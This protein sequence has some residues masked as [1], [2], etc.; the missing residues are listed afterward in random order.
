MRLRFEHKNDHNLVFLL[1]SMPPPR[2]P[3]WI[4]PLR[5]PVFGM[6]WYTTNTGEHIV[7]YSGGG[8]S[9][10]TGVHNHVVVQTKTNECSIS[11]GEKVGIAVRLYGNQEYLYLLVSVGDEIQRYALDEETARLAGSIHLPQYDQGGASLDDMCNA[12]AVNRTKDRL[13][14][15]CE[16]GLVRLYGINDDDTN[17][18]AAFISI[19]QGHIKAVCAVQFSQTNDDTFVSSAKDGTARVWNI[20]KNHLVR[21]TA[22]LTCDCTDPTAKKPM[23]PGTQI[24]VRGCA[25]AGTNMIVTVASPRRGAAFLTGW[26]RDA[27]GFGVGVRTLV[28][29]VPVSAM[30]SSG[31]YVAMGTVDGSII[32][33]NLETWKI[34]RKFDQVHELPVTCLSIRP[35]FDSTDLDITVHVRSASADSKLACLSLQRKVPKANKPERLGSSNTGLLTFIHRIIVGL[36]LLWV[37][38]PM[39]QDASDACGQYWYQSDGSF[40]QRV[41]DVAHCVFEDVLWAPGHRP[42]VATPPY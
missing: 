27:T 11:T 15:G 38:S 26:R 39:I 40:L 30:D 7:A 12:M 20:D 4:D 37:I 25:F 6:A 2:P 3:S 33:W 19:C 16:S 22:T 34:I 24:L 21:S 35:Q 1:T 31:P 42:G 14:L 10:K 36:F 29:P 5:V 41:E 32:L 13:I 17:N 23:K 8:G 9:A 18:F 28:S